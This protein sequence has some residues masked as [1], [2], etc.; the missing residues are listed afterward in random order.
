M[1]GEKFSEASAHASGEVSTC[2]FLIGN[3]PTCVMQEG[4]PSDQE[5]VAQPQT[6]GGEVSDKKSTCGHL[7]GC[8]KGCF[9][10]FLIT[11]PSP[12]ARCRRGIFALPKS[13][14]QILRFSQTAC[15]S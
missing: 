15:P 8:V 11:N 2:V 14:P 9:A 13:T 6:R 4:R 7:P 1:R 12:P 10:K 5:N 3:H